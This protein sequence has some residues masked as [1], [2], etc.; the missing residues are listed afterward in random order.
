MEVLKVELL[1]PVAGVECVRSY[2]VRDLYRVCI[3]S[4]GEYIVSDVVAEVMGEDQLVKILRRYAAGGERQRLDPRVEHVLDR[5]V[6][7]YGVLDALLLDENVV[8]VFAISGIPVSIVHKEFGRLKTNIVLSDEQ[9]SEIIL[10]ASSLSGKSVSERRP[11]PSFMEPRFQSRFSVVYKSDINARRYIALD[12]RRQPLNPWSVFKLV[13]LGTFSLEEAAFLWLMVK[14]RVP[15]MV[16]GELFTGKTTTINAILSMI[17]PDSRVFTIEDAPELAAPSRYWIRT[18][19]REDVD[20]PQDR[21]SVFSLLKIAVRMS[22][23]YIIVG[24]VRGEEA[25]DWAQAILLGHGGLTSFHASTVEAAL[26]RLRSPPIEVPEQALKYLNVFIKME[27]LPTEAGVGLRR[28]TKLYAHDDGKVQLVYTY[29]PA[30]NEIDR[31]FDPFNLNFIAR[32]AKGYGLRIEDLRGELGAMVEVLGE[33]MVELLKRYGDTS[34]IPYSIVPQTL[35]S[36]LEE[37]GFKARL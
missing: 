16:L 15:I 8:D 14:Y 36:K 10:R 2:T 27:P 24:E 34:S 9:L 37:R 23:D 5:S 4:S 31:V 20:N 7:G 1:K 12:I 25:R 22:V 3:T 19:T 17:P 13:D 18:I 28:V 33:S 29:N 26:L 6:N 30:K 21:I 11:I 35:Y 32:I